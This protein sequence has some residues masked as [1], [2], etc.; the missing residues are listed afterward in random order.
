MIRAGLRLVHTLLPGIVHEQRRHDH[1]HSQHHA[2]YDQA[3][4]LARTHVAA[5]ARWQCPS[6]EPPSHR[7]YC[8]ALNVWPAAAVQAKGRNGS[9]SK[10]QPSCVAGEDVGHRGQNLQ[11]HGDE[12]I[13]NLILLRYAATSLQP[14]P[15]QSCFVGEQTRSQHS[16]PSQSLDFRRGVASASNA[17]AATKV[18]ERMLQPS[19]EARRSGCTSEW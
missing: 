6:P 17:S 7:C 18:M 19:I 8:S 14:L 5:M 12:H 13:E 4:C 2:Y 15:L 1:L 11:E 3:V 9:S 10:T 16:R